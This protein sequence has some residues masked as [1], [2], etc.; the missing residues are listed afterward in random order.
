MY[1]NV[2]IPFSLMNQAIYILESIDI[3]NYSD[4]FLADYYD[5]L[6]NLRRKKDSL[7]LHEAYAGIINAKDDDSRHFARMRYLQLKRDI[8]GDF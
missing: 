4:T 5:L 8:K 3:S 1:D 7:H 6:Q 2:K